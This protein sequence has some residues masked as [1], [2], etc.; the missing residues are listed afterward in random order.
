MNNGQKDGTLYRFN[1]V[2]RSAIAILYDPMFWIRCGAA[3]FKAAEYGW[4]NSAVLIAEKLMID[5]LLVMKPSAVLGVYAP[6]VKGLPARIVKASMYVEFFGQPV[7][8]KFLMLFN[9][10]TKVWY[11]AGFLISVSPNEEKF[12]PLV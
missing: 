11:P 4:S 6:F 2:N 10:Q 5:E 3:A 12:I 1:N 8:H 7:D 9:E